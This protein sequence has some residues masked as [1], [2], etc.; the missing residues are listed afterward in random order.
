MKMRCKKRTAA[1]DF[2]KMFNRGPCNRETVKSRCAAP[3]FIKNHERLRRGLIEDR[4]R[5]DHLNHEGRATARQIIRGPHTRKQ[6]INKP[7]TRAL[8]RH[9]TSRLGHD[10]D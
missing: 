6:A 4:S 7:D 5:F 10:N 2:M 1:I 3:D 9:K 8:C